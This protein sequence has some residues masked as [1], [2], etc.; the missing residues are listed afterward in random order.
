M[1]YFSLFCFGLLVR[2]ERTSF[3]GHHC[4]TVNAMYLPCLMY[5]TLHMSVHQSIMKWIVS[6]SPTACISCSFLCFL[7]YSLML[8]LT[9]S[10]H[11]FLLS[12]SKLPRDRQ[13]YGCNL[14]PLLSHLTLDAHGEHITCRACREPWI[15][16]FSSHRADGAQGKWELLNGKCVT[17]SCRWIFIVFFFCE[18]LQ[19]GGWLIGVY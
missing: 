12:L 7:L 13:L 2:L 19:N 6:C 16:L 11:A 18:K 15:G 8:P 14:T 5:L 9:P 4:K 1:R 17:L 3:W 10:G